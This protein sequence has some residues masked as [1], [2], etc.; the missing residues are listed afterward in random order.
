MKIKV[1]WTGSYPCLCHGQWILKING[2]GYS[3]LVPFGSSPANTYGTYSEWHFENWLEVFED[4]EDGLDESDWIKENKEWL[5]KLPS[6][7][8]YSEV[9][10]A[11]QSQDWRH[12]SCGGC[13]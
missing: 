8:N 4:Y 3:D 9:F 2:K 1:E 5:D 11:F 13:I 6:G 10:K 7:T 12:N